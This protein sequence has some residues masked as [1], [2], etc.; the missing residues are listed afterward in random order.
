M[1]DCW[2]WRLSSEKSLKAGPN[3]APRQDQVNN[4]LLPN[5]SANA[6]TTA[7]SAQ[8]LAQA[9][10]LACEPQGHPLPRLQSPRWRDYVAKYSKFENRRIDVGR[11]GS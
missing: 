6:S 3:R 2:R 1:R 9:V 11:E 4:A 10:N 8:T 5:Q 7:A